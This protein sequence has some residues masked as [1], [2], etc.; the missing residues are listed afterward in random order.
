MPLLENWE[1]DVDVD[2]VLRGQGVDPEV[3]RRNRPALAAYAEEAIVEGMPLLDPRVVYR[4]YAVLGVEH[5]RLLLEGGA[6]LRGP[7]VVQHLATAE[8]VVIMLCTI[9]ARLEE[10][11]SQVSNEDMLRGLALDGVGSAAAEALATA[12]CKQFEEQAAEQ[13]LH[14][15]LPLNPGM[16]GWSVEEGQAQIFALL[17]S[18]EAGVTLSAGVMMIPRKS[19]SLVLGFSRQAAAPARPCDYCTL[20]E[21]CRYQKH[22]IA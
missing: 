22:S 13:G 11:A 8:R 7:L 15:T 14:A 19:L 10:H 9:G 12:A 3:I 1:F 6:S 2:M 4:E 18:A 16:E 21:S 20:R 5:D 17:D